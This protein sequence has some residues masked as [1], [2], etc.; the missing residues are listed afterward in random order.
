MHLVNRVCLT[1][2]FRSYMYLFTQINQKASPRQNYRVKF[3]L[4]QSGEKWAMS[5]LI[6]LL[7]KRG[8]ALFSTVLFGL[9]SVFEQHTWILLVRKPVVS[10]QVVWIRTQSVKLHKTFDH[11]KLS[12]G[13]NKK[14]VWRECSF[15]F[16]PSI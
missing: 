12:L 10:I 3:E 2:F 1:G 5:F 4:I 16:T 6:L 7:E 13:V 15:F 8:D 11:F 9:L 14:N